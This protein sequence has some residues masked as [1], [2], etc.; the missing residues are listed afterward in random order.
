MP[1]LKSKPVVKKTDEQQYVY[2][3]KEVALCV[4]ADALTASTA[5]ALLGWMEPEKGSKFANAAFKDRNKVGIVCSNNS[6]NRPFYTATAM[7][8]M[9]EILAGNWKFNGESIIIGR[10]GQILDGQHRLVGLVW[11]AQ[12]WLKDPL[13][14]PF[15]KTIPTIEAILV[16]GVDE[17]I[18]TVN[19][20]NTGR[21]RSLT[22]A[23]YAS[24]LFNAVDSKEAKQ[25]SR[26]VDYTVRTLWV[27]TGY[28]V[29][30][31]SSRR[32]HAESLS[33]VDK[34]PTLLKCVQSVVSLKES[35]P[36]IDE[37]LTLGYCAGLMYLM[38]AS[39]SA[40]EN[41]QCT[42]YRQVAEPTE[43]CLD[44][45]CYDMAL[46]FWVKLAA[47]EFP[48]VDEALGEQ[49]LNSTG[50]EAAATVVIKAWN[51][52]QHDEI[53]TYEAV[54]PLFAR[55]Y[56][57]CTELVEHPLIDGIDQGMVN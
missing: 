40:G 25:L 23:I 50:Q 41:K 51:L 10:N 29:L 37:G 15:W 44:M 17:A 56:E 1:K 45:A 14:Y 8:W 19:T 5:R 46:G 36:S 13:K 30:A 6:H 47:G 52:H 21:P 57:G 33:F 31:F 43:D 54:L 24:K 38:A 48:D 32:T 42:G 11:T 28:N 4:G 55:D 27:R 35:Y 34:H 39:L 20:L 9:Y 26:V 3:T 7:Q 2:P 22:D 18:N 12:E 49:I 53:P 16:F